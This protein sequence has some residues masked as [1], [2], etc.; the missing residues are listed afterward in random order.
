[1]G[2]EAVDRARKGKHHGEGG[3]EMDQNKEG[4]GHEIGRGEKEKDYKK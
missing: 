4:K 3:T 2:R 1:M